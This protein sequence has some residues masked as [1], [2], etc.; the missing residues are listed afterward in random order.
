MQSTFR[1]ERNQKIVKRWLVFFMIILVLSGITALPAESELSFATKFFGERSFVGSWLNDVHIAVKNTNKNYPYLFYGYDWLAL[2]HIVLAIAFVG[3]YKD[4]VKNKWVIEFGAIACLLVIPFA[5]VAG[6]LCGIPFWWRVIDC[7][8]GILGIIPLSICYSK[9]N[10][11]E[12]IIK[13]N[14]LH[15]N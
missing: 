12:A 15:E 7:S 8:F 11:L 2:A 4:P 5:L 1:F 13:S 14:Q 6:Y 3:P 10:E 9:I